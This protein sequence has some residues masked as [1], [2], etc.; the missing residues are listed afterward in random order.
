LFGGF[1]VSGTVKKLWDGDRK[2]EASGHTHPRP[3]LANPARTDRFC[4]RTVK[5]PQDE[6]PRTYSPSSIPTYDRTKQDRWDGLQRETG[7]TLNSTSTPYPTSD[8]PKPAGSSDSSQFDSLAPNA[9]SSGIPINTLKS[10]LSYRPKESQSHAKRASSYVPMS[11]PIAVPRPLNLLQIIGKEALDASAQE[12]VVLATDTSTK[13]EEFQ[14]LPTLNTAEKAQDLQKVERRC[15]GDFSIT[16]QTNSMTDSTCSEDET[17]WEEDS[18][19]DL[20][21][22]H[23]LVD[24]DVIDIGE[25]ENNQTFASGQMISTKV[26]LVSRLMQ[27][28]WSIFNQRWRPELRRRGTTPESSS[29]T[30]N[31][32]YLQSNSSKGKSAKRARG[33]DEEEDYDEQSGKRSKRQAEPSQSPGINENTLQFACPFRK[34]NPRKYCIRNWARC[35]LTAQPTVARVK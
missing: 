6:V 19:E 7:P 9:S 12:I 15:P 2:T 10:S 20:T 22:L 21:P 28:F 1:S 13:E 31:P 34:H 25:E 14:S 3:N 17:D 30:S 23:D 5:P 4:K 16:S 26:Q 11:Y 24:P 32:T 29:S 8:C 35:A 18:D 27:D 33:N